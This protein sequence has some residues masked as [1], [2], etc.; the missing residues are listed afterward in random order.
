MLGLDPQTIL[1][2]LGSGALPALRAVWVDNEHEQVPLTACQP[3]GII[4]NEDE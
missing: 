3:R 4:I 2:A 1:L